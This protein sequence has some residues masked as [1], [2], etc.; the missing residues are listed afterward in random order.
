MSNSTGADKSGKVPDATQQ[1]EARLDEFE[2][3]TIPKQLDPILRDWV[4]CVG[5]VLNARASYQIDNMG[6]DSPKVKY[7]VNWKI[8]D[9]INR[10]ADRNEL[11]DAL[12]TF[13]DE[14]WVRWKV[15]VECER[16][17]SVSGNR[18]V[19]CATFTRY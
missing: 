18:I 8:A 11:A 17:P 7:R 9:I 15:E 6:L 2:G 19:F 14:S 4:I 16:N 1:A 13:M 12:Q 3:K 5:Q 10:F